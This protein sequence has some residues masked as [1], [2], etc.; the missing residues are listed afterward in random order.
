MN[1]RKKNEFTLEIFLVI[2]ALALG[3]LFHLTVGYK[4]TVLN[5]FF[6]PVVLAGFFLGRYRAST[7]ALL[8]VVVTSAAAI[9]DLDGFAAYTSPLVIALSVAIWGAVLG[10]TAIL[11]GTLSDERTQ[12]A[13][14]L[15]E[16]YVGVVEV[17]SKYLQG[18]NPMLEAR[19]NRVA[20]LSQRVGRR[21][22]LSAREIDNIRV[23]ALLH[24]LENIKITSQVIQKAVSDVE[25]DVNGAEKHTFRGCDLARSLGTVLTGALPLLLG[26][27]DSLQSGLLDEETSRNAALPIGAEIIRTVRAYDALR[28]GG[29]G[30][31]GQTPLAAIDELIKDDHADFDAKI[32]QA[33]TAEVPRSGKTE[34]TDPVNVS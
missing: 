25:M 22:H 33:L 23:A 26:Q 16:A 24:D 34:E 18:A 27:D 12:K 28:Q 14:E 30:Q 20:E 1:T 5:L 7:L 8:C 6:L 13:A 21:M 2:I 29:W 15:H 17:L 4:M 10:L 9:L 31:L 19:S 3:G 32:I 11:V